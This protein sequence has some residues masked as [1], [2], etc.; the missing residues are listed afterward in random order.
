MIIDDHVHITYGLHGMI[1]SGQTRSLTYGAIKQGDRVVQF[2]PPLNSGKT[3]FEPEM[4]LRFM[5]GLGVDKAVLLQGSMYG[6]QNV[7]VYKAA[8]KWPDRLIPVAYLDPMD[9]AVHDQFRKVVDEY[10]FRILKFEMSE[11][12]GF[13]GLY[14]DLRLNGEEMIWI[15][16][17]AERRNLI[18]MLDLGPT[19]SRSYQTDVVDHMIKQHPALRIVIAHLGYPP[20]TKPNNVQLDQLWQQQVMLGRHPNVWFDLAAVNAYSHEVGEDYPFATALAYIRRA[21]E[22]IGADKLMWGTDIPSSLQYATYL[23]HLDFIRR[24]CTFLSDG[25]I[26]QVIGETA[27]AVYG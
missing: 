10:G 27:I 12:A 15:W 1:Y 8:T 25:Q 26:K 24:H 19:N 4:L 23:Q 2:L 11:L 7:D 3:V 21:V 16:E 17:E 9:T 6:D 22:M 14:P 13:T 5:D 20:I 18:V